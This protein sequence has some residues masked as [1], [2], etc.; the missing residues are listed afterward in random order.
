MI[1]RKKNLV[2]GDWSQSILLPHTPKHFVL[3]A[4]LVGGGGG[5]VGNLG[6]IVVRVSEPIFRNL[7]Q[8][9][10]SP[11]KKKKKKQQQQKTDP[12]IY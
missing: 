11:L 9:Y 3:G 6:V 10:T 4:A 1:I 5:L 12:F 2:T 7:P 8:S